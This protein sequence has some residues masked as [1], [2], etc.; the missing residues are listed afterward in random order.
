MTALPPSEPIE[1]LIEARMAAN[2]GQLSGDEY[3]LSPAVTRAMLPFDQYSQA[4]LF[5]IAY[6][7]GTDFKPA[8]RIPAA[9]VAHWDQW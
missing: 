8:S 2:L 3:F 7:K 4:G 9:E 6:T 5:P 1:E